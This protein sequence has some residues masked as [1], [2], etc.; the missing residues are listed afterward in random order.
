MSKPKPKSVL[1]VNCK[2]ETKEKAVCTLTQSYYDKNVN[3][4]IVADDPF[5]QQVDRL[6]WTFSQSAF[7]PHGIYRQGE[8]PDDDRIVIVTEEVNPGNADLCIA[9]RPVDSP[10]LDSFQTVVDVEQVGPANL[11]ARRERYKKY[12]DGGRQVEYREM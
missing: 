6:L 8:E 5:A 2:S 1:F 7:L 4:L 10:F 9:T 11:E 12:K 3:V